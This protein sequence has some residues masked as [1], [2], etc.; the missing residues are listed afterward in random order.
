MKKFLAL[1][2]VVAFFFQP[3]PAFGI[4]GLSKCE[5]A[6]KAIKAEETI[7]AVLWDSFSK[8]RRSLSNPPL[9]R[10]I[11]VLEQLQLVYKSDDV[12]F[13][14]VEKNLKCFTPKQVAYARG[15]IAAHKEFYKILTGWKNA[16]AKGN[17]SASDSTPSGLLEWT[18]SA[19]VSYVSFLK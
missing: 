14:I 11:A 9:S 5:K 17:R 15:E 1:V 4:F 8:S 19:Y 16:I 7:G 10:T 18:K 13:G 3:S 12:V 6:I 2:V